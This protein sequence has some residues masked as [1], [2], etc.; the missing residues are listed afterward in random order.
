MIRANM[1]EDKEAAKVR[2]LHG[3]NCEIANVMKLQHYV[4]LESHVIK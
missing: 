4:E 1:E 2:F 3:L